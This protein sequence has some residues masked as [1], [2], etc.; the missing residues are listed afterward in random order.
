MLTPKQSCGTW[1]EFIVGAYEIIEDWQNVY[2]TALDSCLTYTNRPSASTTATSHAYFEFDFSGAP[3]AIDVTELTKAWYSGEKDNNGV[4]LSM[5]N[6]TNNAWDSMIFH[7]SRNAENAPYLSVL[8]EEGAEPLERIEIRLDSSEHLVGTNPNH[9]MDIGIYPESSRYYYINDIALTSSNEN[10]AKIFKTNSEPPYVLYALDE[11]TTTVTATLTSNPQFTDTKEFTVIEPRA[12]D[13]QIMLSSNDLYG[14]TTVP[15][16]IECLPE[17]Y[18]ELLF[19]D[20]ILTSSN[21]EVIYVGEKDYTNSCFYVNLLSV[22]TTTLTAT[23]GDYSKS[24]EVTTVNT[25]PTAIEI[26]SNPTNIN[27][28]LGVNP[29]IY[30]VTAV[31]YPA[32]AS[33]DVVFTSSEPGVAETYCENNEWFIRVKAPGTTVITASSSLDETITDSFELTAVIGEIENVVVYTSST[34]IG[35]NPYRDLEI[36][37][38]PYSLKEYYYDDVEITSSDENVA[39]VSY[40]GY[41]SGSLYVK[42]IGTTTLT[43][44]VGDF[45][46]TKEIEVYY[47]PITN[48]SITN[49]EDCNFLHA[50]YNKTCTLE[51]EVT[52]N[53]ASSA[54]SLEYHS[55]N[56]SVAQI[57]GMG[58]ITA[59]SAGTTYISASY[60]PDD[61]EDGFWLTVSDITL[62]YN[63]PENNCINVGDT[64]TVSTDSSIS[65]SAR[66]PGI[67][68]INGDGTIT[69][70]A[71][72]KTVIEVS[73]PGLDYF[74]EFELVV[75]KD[76]VITGIPT[77]DI[78]PGAT[79]QPVIEG[80]IASSDTFV[81]YTSD[82]SIASISK[83]EID[84]VVLT[85]HAP[86]DV[87]VG[88]TI[89]NSGIGQEV[90]L[91]VAT[92]EIT[93]VTLLDDGGGNTIYEGETKNFW[94]HLETNPAKVNTSY[95]DIDWNFGTDFNYAKTDQNKCIAQALNASADQTNGTPITLTIADQEYTFY[96][97]VKRPTITVTNIPTRELAIGETYQLRF[98]VDGPAAINHFAVSNP[99]IIDITKDGK[100]TVK[101][102][103]TVTI[104]LHTLNTKTEKHYETDSFTIQTFLPVITINNT[105]PDI[106]YVGETYQLNLSKTPCAA[107]G[108]WEIS[109]SSILE[110]NDNNQIIVKGV[111][112]ATVNLY[113]QNT[114]T[115]KPPYITDS[116]SVTTFEHKITI[117]NEINYLCVGDTYTFNYKYNF[118][119]SSNR[120]VEWQV[121]P[122]DCAT[123][124]TSTGKITFLKPTQ[125]TIIVRDVSN[126]SLTDQLTLSILNYS[127]TLQETPMLQDHIN[128]KQ[129]AEDEYNVWPAA[130]YS[131]F[132]GKTYLERTSNINSTY[133]VANELLLGYLA[134]YEES[135]SMLHHYLYNAGSN[136]NMDFAKMN[137]SWDFAIEEKEKVINDV[138]RAAEIITTNKNSAEF[139][140]ASYERHNISEFSD[141]GFSIGKYATKIK[142]NV[143]K[144]TNTYVATI[145]YYLYDQYDWNKESYD[146]VHDLIPLSQRDLWELHHG[147]AAKSYEVFGEETIE[148]T[149]EKGQIYI[150]T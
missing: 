93:G 12:E 135:A 15:C 29:T 64:F 49:K 19:D 113:T 3:E 88:F 16:Y 127:E 47:L 66:T 70:L 42:N 62:D 138:M 20:V 67:V 126:P 60:D 76:F 90:S 101:E 51:V 55:S 38:Y 105:P 74:E 116:F 123:I 41:F 128:S 58:N 110:I 61:V 87:Y 109:D 25:R 28:E 102:A 96:R 46:T 125:A 95:L 143:T 8:F 83:N 68:R 103:G 84:G 120:T 131:I 31:L 69:G 124:N 4:K 80:E 142:C 147:G 34:Q 85:C 100:I 79:I 112:T 104:E 115:N 7:S 33:G 44:R 139:I 133:L 53:N 5:V 52:P 37:L 146:N 106:M 21:P 13:I 149:W 14:P 9:L 94:V 59:L 24:I 77:E 145:T 86:G 2:T 98:N 144:N 119:N 32:N 117:T 136:Y 107:V 36:E 10:V 72:G 30:K 114:I 45:V 18:S 81:W 141:Y 121:V 130:D 132:Y 27:V 91:T 63:V 137:S 71:V 56:P 150:L 57:D 40:N 122:E 48:I 82:S 75:T 1:S 17:I 11:G 23:V 148:I 134:G 108:K 6:E 54:L 73:H 111:G 97:L 89:G 129:S 140:S 65:I 35:G 22:G 92:P 78:Y 26:T 39:T 99:S 50:F 43:V 118:K